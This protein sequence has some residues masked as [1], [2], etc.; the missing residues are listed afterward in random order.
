MAVTC[1]FTVCHVLQ[2]IGRERKVIC[3]I[4]KLGRNVLDT[5]ISCCKNFQIFTTRYHLVPSYII[6]IGCYRF[7]FQH[8]LLHI[9]YLLRILFWKSSTVA[10]SPCTYYKV[11]CQNNYHFALYSCCLCTSS[12]PLP[13]LPIPPYLDPAPFLSCVCGRYPAWNIVGNLVLACIFKFG[14]GVY[15]AGHASVRGRGCANTV[16]FCLLSLYIM[17]CVWFSF[18]WDWDSDYR[19]LYV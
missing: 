19:Y 13:L 8:M 11:L 4:W 1:T 9:L 12:L 3:L 16:L 18:I 14:F 2:N 7:W 15:C 5:R 10:L 17:Q 6:V